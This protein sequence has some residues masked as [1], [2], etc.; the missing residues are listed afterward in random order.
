MLARV[1][2]RAVEVF[3][4]QDLAIDWLKH[5]NCALRNQAPLSLLDTE[6]R[7]ES[8]MDLLGR[9]EIVEQK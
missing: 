5:P 8:V 4:K 6:F 7:A 9:I 2:R 1:V 3:E